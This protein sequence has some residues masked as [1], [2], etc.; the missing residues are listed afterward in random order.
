MEVIIFTNEK[1]DI[2]IVGMLQVQWIET[3]KKCQLIMN[4]IGYIKY[5]SHVNFNQHT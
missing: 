5:D 4:I 1:E 3:I 2:N